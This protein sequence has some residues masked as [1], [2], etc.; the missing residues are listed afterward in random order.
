MNDVSTE[1]KIEQE[2]VLAPAAGEAPEELPE[3]RSFAAAFYRFLDR[4]SRPILGSAGVALGIASIATYNNDGST[5]RMFLL[6]CASLITLS[7]TFMQPRVGR[8]RREWLLDFAAAGGVMLVCAPIYLIALYDWPI[9]VNSDEVV[10]ASRMQEYANTPDMDLLGVTGYLG[11]PALLFVGLGK[12]GQAIGGID[13]FHVRLLHASIGLLAI[14]AAY[15]FLRQL[16]PRRWAIVATLILGLNHSLFMLSRMAMRENTALLVEVVALGLLLWGLRRDRL[17]ATFTG[18]VVAGLGFYVYFPGRAVFALWMVA[19]VSL[20]VFF[21]KRLGFKK[22][23]RAGA[24]ATLGFALMASPVVIAGLKAPPEFN[25]Q[26]RL[27]LMIFPESRQIQKEWVAADTIAEGYKTNVAWGLSTFNNTIHDHAFAYPNEGHGF[28]DPLTGGL[29]WIGVGTAIVRLI[30]G[31]SEPWPLVA[32]AGFLTLWLA[33]AFLINK[34]PNYPRLLITLPFVAYFVAEA[35]RGVAALI[36][37]L[38]KRDDAKAVGFATAAVACI[39]VVVIGGWNLAIANDFMDRGER[40]G[41]DIGDTGRYIEEH[42]ELG[43]FFLSA[44]PSLRYYVWGDSYMWPDRLALFSGS[45][46]NVGAIPPK[47]L[48]TWQGTPPFAIFMGRTVWEVHKLQ[49]REHYPQGHLETVGATGW[50]KV[51]VVPGI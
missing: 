40:K 6:W 5:R 15:F 20:A 32:V 47:E 24:V 8:P 4:Y 37:G 17:L 31:R 36:A 25:E 39:V 2:P 22:I 16:L 29:L 21:H 12:L 49:L 26:Q 48:K 23:V 10:I 18:G 1:E 13:L 19:L 9:Q 14:G 3:P 30:R 46:A 33:Y 44:G 41:D 34:A 27:A 11:H 28:V 43:A 7:L 50:H 35:I 42:P 38:I 45:Y 51:F